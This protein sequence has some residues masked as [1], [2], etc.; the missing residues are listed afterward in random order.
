MAKNLDSVGLGTTV[1]AA[2]NAANMSG[3]SGKNTVAS[4][5]TYTVTIDQQNETIELT[6]SGTKIVTL[7]LLSTIA[8]ALHTDDFKVTLF[9][10]GAGAATINVNAADTFNDG[11][12]A[13]ILKDNE[14]VTL[15]SSGTSTVWNVISVVSVAISPNTSATSTTI[16]NADRVVLNDNGTMVQVA[17]TDVDTYI[18]GTAKTL[19]NKTLKNS[20]YS[21]SNDNEAFE[22]SSTASAVNQ[23]K[24][25][26][27]ATGDTVEYQ[28]AG[29]DTNINVKLTP[30][31][32]GWEENNV[33][34]A[35]VTDTSDQSINNT[36]WTH[37]N[38]NSETGG[39][40]TNTIHDTSTNNQRLTV[41]TGVTYIRLLASVNW[42]TAATGTRVAQFS[43]NDETTTPAS[44]VGLSR[45]AFNAGGAIGGHSLTSAIIAVTGGD[46]FTVAVWHN[47]GV[48]VDID[49][50]SGEHDS[51]FAMEIIK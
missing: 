38:W 10:T 3:L 51:W 36:T 44:V 16:A 45:S 42:V 20:I 21:D 40:D 47:D 49:M 2:Q 29:G 48:A 17:M 4:G 7:T 41:P 33:Q 28:A 13:F 43:K 26:N 11:T 31:G 32:S 8:T 1:S 22:I 9:N 50:T 46:Y 34:G 6:N 23:P 24:L 19:T 35:L 12:T 5:A 30:K 25:V 27:S 39:Y 37:I 18:S 14:A 15:S